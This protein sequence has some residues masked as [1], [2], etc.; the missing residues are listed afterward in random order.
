[1][2]TATA[3]ASSSTPAA[4]RMSQIGARS[5]VANWDMKKASA[6]VDLCCEVFTREYEIGNSEGLPL[7]D[8]QADAETR[9]DWLCSLAAAANGG[10]S[11]R[12]HAAHSGDGGRS[13]G[14]QLSA[15]VPAVAEVSKKE[16][17]IKTFQ[18][19]FG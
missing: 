4:R 8:L 11:P 1:M 5:E 17:L 15:R 12:V 16:Y 18:K 14:R 13:L 7:S 9:P 6:F 3:T 10:L 2:P 19:T